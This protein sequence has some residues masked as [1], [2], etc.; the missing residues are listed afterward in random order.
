MCLPTTTNSYT[1][2]AVRSRTHASQIR[3]RF[4]D[5]LGISRANQQA[6]CVANKKSS[7][8]P[9]RRRK[10]P[11]TQ[12]LLKSDSGEPDESLGP[13]SLSSISTPNNFGGRERKNGKSVAFENAV[14]VH[15]IPTRHE[16]SGR[17]RNTLWTN[18]AEM[19]RNYN[20]NVIEFTAENWD[21]RQC[22]EEEHFFVAHNGELI[23]PVHLQQERNLK[24]HFCAVM[25]AQQHEQRAY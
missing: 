10:L 13:N 19:Q 16:F 17:I 23:H 4:L 15:Q 2:R 20:R 8:P 7:P 9:R 18:A 22:L 24:W 5:T 12:E 14:T 21:Y 3:S 1:H 6:V 11:A 25:C